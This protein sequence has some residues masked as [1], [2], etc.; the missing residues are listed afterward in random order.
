MD[1]FNKK[2]WVT[3]RRNAETR[4]YSGVSLHLV[5]NKYLL[6][7]NLVLV[8]VHVQLLVQG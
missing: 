4:Q 6:E 2:K 1:K 7:T 8:D 5:R 3:F